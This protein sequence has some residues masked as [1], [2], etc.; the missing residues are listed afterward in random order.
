[1]AEEADVDIEGDVADCSNGTYEEL[2]A[3]FV[4]DHSLDSMWKSDGVL[5]P[6]T[7]DSTIS[8]E[9]RA[10]I[11][12]ML[13][14]EE[15]YLSNKPLPAKFWSDS[16][17][18][19][20]AARSPQKKTVRVPM[21]S[22]SKPSSGTVKW[23]AEEKDLFEQGLARFGRRWTNI[24]RLIGS[25]T[26]LQVKSYA[27][28]YF[29]NKCKVENGEKDSKMAAVDL[30]VLRADN[31]EEEAELSAFRGRSDPNL[32]A[33][34]IETLSDDEE[35]DITDEVDEAFVKSE[36]LPDTEINPADKICQVKEETIHPTPGQSHLTPERPHTYVT[37]TDSLCQK[38]SDDG[39]A[40]YCFTCVSHSDNSMSAQDEGVSQDS[41]SPSTQDKDPDIPLV[42]SSP[43]YEH[44]DIQD[45]TE[46]LKPPDQEVELDPDFIQEEEKQAIP[47]FFEGR[48]A[49]TPERYLRIRNYILDRWR[50]SKP[51]YLNKTSVRPGLKNCGDVNCI[52]RI[53]TYLELIGAINLGC[54]Q[55]VYNRPRPLDKTK[56]KL[57][58]DTLEAYELAHRLQ[59]MRTRRRRVRDPWGNWCDARDLE[60]QTFE[61][62][63]AEELAQRRERMKSLKCSKGSRPPKSAFDP[64]QLIP[65]LNF[66]EEKQAPFR[67]MISAEAMLILDL[68]SH[69]SLAEVIGLLGGRYL[70]EDRIVEIWAAEPC[71][72][73]STGLQCEMDPVSQTQASEALSLRGY[74]VIG[75]YHSHPAFDPNPSIRDIDTQAKYQSYFSRGGA[76]FLG[77]II[78]P[79][80]RSN[81][82]PQSQLSC[83]VISEDLSEDGSYRM[84]YR[85]D[86]ELMSGQPSW[87]AIFEKTRWIINKYRLSHSSVPM[88]KRFRQD[89]DLTCLQKLLTCLKR[90]LMNAACSAFADEFLSRIEEYFLTSYTSIKDV[91]DAGGGLA[92][93]AEIETSASTSDTPD[94]A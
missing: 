90:T 74:S 17:N 63:S 38:H 6:W 27:R 39:E 47:E 58:K 15:Y 57:V 79:Y 3:G 52:G 73:L 35:V 9:N 25:R 18:A 10:A 40:F 50:N 66:T 42:Q 45:E 89:S 60:G 48:P 72:S 37:E 93:A 87:E 24:A 65:C 21:R 70:E 68:H 81:P 1:M 33:V 64:F 12:K 75:W 69:V 82:L 30:P 49:K 94:N 4:P 56:T 59:T 2:S 7:L 92:A 22:P 46:D 29:K 19:E 20:K 78:S 44:E 54:E 83:L 67:V 28:Q 84:P 76:K 41:T 61:H 14:E 91:D 36:D 55:A 88:N 32:N 80:N 34:K 16:S 5:T 85:F 51:N 71:N 8:D 62:L 23:T 26:V 31:S 13:L 77:M 11:E 53:H 43:P 86:V